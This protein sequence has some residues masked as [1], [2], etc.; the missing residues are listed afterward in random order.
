MQNKAIVFG[1]VGLVAVAVVVTIVTWVGA[2]GRN[3][4]PDV[5]EEPRRSP[6]GS[7]SGPGSGRS[8]R[9]PRARAK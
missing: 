1:G 7:G 4:A 3:G 8:Y 2:Q 5:S 9:V 6:S